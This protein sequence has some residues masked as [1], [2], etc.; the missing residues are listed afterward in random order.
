MPRISVVMPTLNQQRYL[1]A[2][3][4]SILNQ[5]CDVEIIVID[6]GSTDGSLDILKSYGEQIRFVSERDRGQ[7]DALNKGLNLITGDIVGWLNSDDVYKQDAF[8]HVL[9]MFDEP[10]VKWIY[11]MVDVIDEQGNEIRKWVTKLK[12]RRLPKLT[13]NQLLQTNWISQMGVFWRRDFLASVG[14]LQ[15]NYHLA[16]DYDL[17]LRFWRQCP[18]IYLDQT[19]ASFRLYETSKS[20]GQYR[21]QLSEAYEIAKRHAGRSYPLDLARHAMNRRLISSIYSV[22]QLLSPGK[23]GTAESRITESGHSVD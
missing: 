19:I 6:G 17:W 16:M 3:I 14:G 4:D 5:S 8:S 13:F 15:T 9:P 10:N 1:G 2:A 12:N 23:P 7:S 22:L 11:G 20:G 21:Q 18:G